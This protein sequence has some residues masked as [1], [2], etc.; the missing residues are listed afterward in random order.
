M[1]TLLI[2]SKLFRTLAF[3]LRTASMSIHRAFRAIRVWIC[4]HIKL[5]EWGR[6]RPGLFRSN[7][8]QEALQGEVQVLALILE[9]RGRKLSAFPSLVLWW[10]LLPWINSGVQIGTTNSI[11]KLSLELSTSSEK[12]CEVPRRHLTFKIQSWTISKRLFWS[13][14][15]TRSIFG[16]L[17]WLR[18]MC[19]MNC[20]LAFFYAPFFISIIQN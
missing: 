15:W 16:A 13:D 9:H 5:L 1:S 14:G 18:Q 20:G 7:L 2:F 3:L 4:K 17:S 10:P 6:S 8:A 12:A 19:W 11:T